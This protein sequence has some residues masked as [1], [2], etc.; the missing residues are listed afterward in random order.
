MGKSIWPGA[1]LIHSIRSC[2]SSPLPLSCTSTEERRNSLYG[3]DVTSLRARLV[4]SL[5]YFTPRFDM[6]DMGIWRLA[7][8]IGPNIG[9]AFSKPGF[10]P[11]GGKS[12]DAPQLPGGGVDDWYSIVCAR[13]PKKLGHAGRGESERWG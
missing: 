8:P 11:C 4:L 2:S 12:L 9:S 7:G 13:A 6:T 3:Q 1:T 5:R 10:S